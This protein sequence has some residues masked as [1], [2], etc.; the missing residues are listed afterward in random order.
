MAVDDLIR[1]SA[2]RRQVLKSLAGGAAAVGTFLSAQTSA[3]GKS[4]EKRPS[5]T[6]DPRQADAPSKFE[7]QGMIY[8]RLGRTG[9]HISEIALGGSPLPDESLLRR[10]IDR[11]VNYVDLS[12]SYENGNAERKMGRLWKDIGRDKIHVHTRFH[13]PRNFSEQSIIASVEG[14][15]RRLAVDSIDI[16]GIHGVENPDHVTD[17]RILGAFEKLRG[18]GKF[19]FRGLTCHVNQHAVI[20]KAVE[21]GLYDMVQVGYNVFDIQETDKNVK[22]YSDY[23]GESGI[24][25]LIDL[26]HSRDV[27]V[28]AMKVLKVGGRRQNLAG[29]VS[30]GI[31]LHQAMIKWALGNAKISAVVIEIM[32][33]AEMDEDLA[34]AGGRLSR[35][36]RRRLHTHVSARAGDYCHFCGLCQGA[37]RQ[38]IRT[39]DLSRA[40]VYA[41]SYGKSDRAK[42]AVIA[43]TARIPVTVCRNC[44][45]CEQACPYGLAVRRRT[46]RAAALARA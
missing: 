44:G 32:N 16:L 11:G 5:E 23:L 7:R 34:A 45:A 42:A 24:A 30:E 46:G 39:A 35:E 10:L 31:S 21:S 36:E 18:Q 15:L 19:R 40:L 14:S 13:L 28:T 1:H 17:E 20:P 26:A 9:L 29:A 8:R 6:E 4:S 37:C 12:D 33:T 25:K 38:G 22:T 3:N 41:E 2:S 27:G 43:A